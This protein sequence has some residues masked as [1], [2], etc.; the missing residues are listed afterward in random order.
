M[1]TRARRV[2]GHLV[3]SVGPTRTLLQDGH[4]A[5]LF[6][7]ACKLL[8]RCDQCWHAG[9][10]GGCDYGGIPTSTRHGNASCLARNPT[11]IFRSR[12]CN[13][14]QLH[15]RV[16]PHGSA[17]RDVRPASH[18]DRGS[19]RAERPA[20]C[21]APGGASPPRGVDPHQRLQLPLAQSLWRSFPVATCVAPR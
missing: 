1:A 13:R 4:K 2:C 19:T 12:Q 15:L 3:L 8:S 21:A 14:P 11:R 9:C 5:A 10:V 17:A 6:V 7:T 20:V 16:R 18:A